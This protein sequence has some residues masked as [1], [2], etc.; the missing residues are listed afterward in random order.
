VTE[1]RALRD[2][3][4]E[5][6]SGWDTW[7]AVYVTG[8]CRC[9]QR[10]YGLAGL[11]RD[12]PGGASGAGGSGRAGCRVGGPEPAGTRSRG[13]ATIGPPQPPGGGRG[14]EL[15]FC[16]VPFIL[17][18]SV[19]VQRFPFTVHSGTMSLSRDAARTS[20]CHTTP[21]RFRSD[22]G[23]REAA[24]DG[25]VRRDRRQRPGCAA[26]GGRKRQADKVLRGAQ[27]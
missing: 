10:E 24:L 6:S 7:N 21:V 15:Q 11:Y 8:S 25:G 13:A 20:I 4:R 5:P 23:D 16:G 14:A 17:A 9:C 26:R 18:S 27:D 22:A 3:H 12:H 19:A 2:G 1:P